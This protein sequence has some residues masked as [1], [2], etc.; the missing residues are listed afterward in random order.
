MKKKWFIAIICMSIYFGSEK[1]DVTNLQNDLVLQN[2]EALANGEDSGPGSKNCY[3]TMTEASSDD[4]LAV[5]LRYCND[6]KLKWCTA[7]N[8]KALC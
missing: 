4:F 1:S 8:D 6:C 7:V 2:I 3:R 5:E